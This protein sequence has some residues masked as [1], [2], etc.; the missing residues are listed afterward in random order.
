MQ[1]EQEKAGG[2]RGIE[3]T[4]RPVSATE[5]RDTGQGAGGGKGDKKTCGKK[6]RKT[7][8]GQE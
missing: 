3:R 4:T 7:R 1:E 8:K 5:P 6:Q 2:E